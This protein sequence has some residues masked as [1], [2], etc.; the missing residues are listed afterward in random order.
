MACELEAVGVGDGPFDGVAEGAAVPSKACE[1]VEGI[2]M[3]EESRE[4]YDAER[5]EEGFGLFFGQIAQRVS[6]IGAWG[7]FQDIVHL[8]DIGF[9]FVVVS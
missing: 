2:W 8:L 7:D 3:N 5:F 9:G 6:M 4:V 1:T